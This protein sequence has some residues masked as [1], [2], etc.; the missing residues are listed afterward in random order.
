VLVGNKKSANY[1]N[2]WQSA[3]IVIVIAAALGNPLDFPPPIGK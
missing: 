1:K 2:C 3:V